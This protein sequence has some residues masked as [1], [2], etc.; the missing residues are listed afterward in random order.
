MR[1]C[2]C[3]GRLTNLN[4]ACLPSGCQLWS[5]WYFK[6]Q[7]LNLYVNKGVKMFLWGRVHECEGEFTQLSYSIVIKTMLPILDFWGRYRYLWAPMGCFYKLL[8][9]VKLGS[10]SCRQLRGLRQSQQGCAQPFTR[11]LHTQRWF[12]FKRKLT[13]HKTGCWL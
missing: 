5:V 8:Q 7:R 6:R 1:N 10:D 9:S 3:K 12:M 13:L 11:R 4:S 2:L